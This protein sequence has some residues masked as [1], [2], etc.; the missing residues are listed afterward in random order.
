MNRFA[1]MHAEH[2]ARRTKPRTLNRP[3]HSAHVMFQMPN[4]HPL[5]D[6]IWSEETYRDSQQPTRY[7]A[8]DARERHLLWAVCEGAAI[9]LRSFSESIRTSAVHWLDG[10]PARMPLW[11]V[12]QALDWQ[13]GDLRKAIIALSR[14]RVQRFVAVTHQGHRGLKA[15]DVR[16][17]P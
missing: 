12:A 17:T 5:V 16:S 11:W 15:Q 10:G 1:Q 6:K 4:A 14:T 7:V 9:D 2:A 3:R 8:L 13:P